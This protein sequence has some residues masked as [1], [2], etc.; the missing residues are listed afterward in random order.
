MMKIM[1]SII[2]GIVLMVLLPQVAT[3]MIGD[4]GVRLKDLCRLSTAKDNA[5]VG[6]GV[7]TGLAGTGDSVRSGATMQSIR[8]ILQG[9]GVNVPVSEVHSRNAAAIMVTATLP[10]YAQ[11]GD[12]LDINVTSL[13]DA[14]SLLGGTLLMT[15]LMAADRQTYAIAQGPVS[16]G[17][18][19]YDL[20]GNL[21]QK[22][23]PT[24]ASIPGGATVERGLN[25]VLLDAGGAVY[26]NLYEPDFA[27]A[28]RVVSALDDLLGPGKARAIDAARIQVTV[29]ESE[30]ANLVGFLSRVESTLVT[31][32]RP[33]RVVVNERTGTV[34]AGGNVRIAP[35]TISHGDLNVA[36]STE[37]S[38]SQP[39]LVA[40]TGR[41]VRTQVVPKT[42][43]KVDEEIGINVSLP[44]H[45][46]VAEL[47]AALNKV[48]AS[49]RDII[50]ILQGVKRAGALHAELV[51]Q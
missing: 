32:D 27:T 47:V 26:Y 35:V 49:S 7:V 29:P 18:F 24:S 4:E 36:I 51:I 12:K 22:N 16:V 1:R 34:V 20:N 46:T 9:F 43:I 19:S 44:R 31:P 2:A 17:G 15:H 3:A 42:D 13:G 8:N 41:D 28:S 48:K 37:F 10:P 40:E 14:R 6:Y 30:R 33:S 21:I 38:V 25:A 5:L 50:T 11:Q 39:F 45:S 23:H